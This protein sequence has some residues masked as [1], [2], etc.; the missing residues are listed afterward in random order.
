M[1][2]QRAK[3]PV[4]LMRSRYSAYALGGFGDY[5]LATWSPV[6]AAGLS[7]AEL[8]VRSVEWQEL[9]ILSKSQQGDVG[10][11]E[12]KARFLDRHGKADYHHETSLFERINGRWLYVGV[13]ED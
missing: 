10:T 13:V 9:L 1:N 12:F 3:T 5:L 4:Q 11:V 6:N 8:S 2:E 7:A